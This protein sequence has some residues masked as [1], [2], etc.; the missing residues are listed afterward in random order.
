MT[1]AALL[2]IHNLHLSISANPTLR[3]V[4]LSVAAGKVH[5]LVGESGAGKS[6]IARAVLG[7]L[8][9]LARVTSGTV[10]F[11]E[12]DLLTLAERELR[13]LRG[14]DIALIP[15]NPMTALNPVARIEPQITDV[16][17]MHLRLDAKAA[18]V[19]AL[20]LLNEV[21]LREPERVLRQ[22]PH[23]LSGGMR[24]RVCIAIAFACNPKLVIADEPTTALDVTVQKQILRLIREMQSQ[25]QTAVLF[26]SHDLGVVAKVCDE[27]SVLH[28]GRVLEH[29]T[30]FELFAQPRHE[31]TRALL[32]ATPRYDRPG[33]A[34]RPLPMELQDRLRLEARE[35]D[36]SRSK[37]L[38]SQKRSLPPA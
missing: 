6:M 1:M 35:S 17:R 10:R 38:R 11:A 22:F 2:D 26:I 24:Q 27:V 12:R 21:H 23:Q 7:L 9:A 36:S 37:F 15:Q 25:H 8:P 18:R 13:D 3:G 28:A 14:R 5:G 31:Y 4:S 32:A 34:L 19:R 33:E 30:T 29:N 16:L 20:Q